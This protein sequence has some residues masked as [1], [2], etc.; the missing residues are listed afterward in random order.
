M[1]TSADTLMLLT[2]DLGTWSTDPSRPNYANPAYVRM[3]PRWQLVEDIRAG[4]IA[5]RQK[6]QFYLPRFEAETIEDWQARVGMTFVMDHYA[7]TI[8]EHVGLVFAVPPKLG[9][10][11][12]AKIVALTEDIDGEGNHLDVFAETA[13]DNALHQGHCVLFTDYPVA[14]HIKTKA[15]EKTAQVRPYVTLY[16][17]SDVLS[18][19]T[20]TVGGVKTLV[21]IVLRESGTDANGEFGTQPVTRYREIKQDVYYDQ[22]TGRATGLGAITWRAWKEKSAATPSDTA[23]NASIADDAFVPDGQGEIKGPTRI[24]ARIVY[25][26]QK[27]GYLESIPHLMGL[28]FS[29]IEETQVASDYANIMHK[30]NVPTPIFIGRNTSPDANGQ[31]VQMGQGIDIPQG[32]D[33]KMLEPSGVAINATRV[34]IEDLRA[35]MRRQGATTGDET[36]KVMTAIEAKIYAKQ[37]NAKLQRAARSLQDALEGVLSDMAAFMG[38]P[39]G[40]SVAISQN[41]SEEGIDPTYL[42]VLVTAYAQGALPLDALLHALETGKLPD[43]FSSTDSALKLIADEMAR[44]DAAA[45]QA[46]AMAA[47]PQPANGG[48]GPDGNGGNG[49]APVPAEHPIPVAAHTRQAPGAA[50][51]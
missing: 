41:F 47:N 6:R 48:G 10:D 30:C 13:L 14:D 2:S 50:A 43:D 25:G 17:A 51:A 29:N 44:Q 4:T 21:Q 31:T 3:A 9:Q 28:A 23:P 5:I 40:G 34:R 22:I 32:G 49:V 37:R 42:T 38:L 26:G 16:R 33:A 8:T 12:P 46:K 20:V 1:L 15:D 27:V 19:R 18:W 7:T 24:C 45:E 11:V 35:Q 39:D 36:G